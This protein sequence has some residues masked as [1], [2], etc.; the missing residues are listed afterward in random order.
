MRSFV[1][2]NEH[3][4]Y[5]FSLEDLPGF[6]RNFNENKHLFT[7][8]SVPLFLREEL[9]G[10]DNPIFLQNNKNN[11]KI[12]IKLLRDF[13]FPSFIAFA[14]GRK[15]KDK[16]RELNVIFNNEQLGEIISDFIK[17]CIIK[18]K[19]EEEKIDQPL[20]SE[21]ASVSYGSL[22]SS[23]AYSST[24]DFASSISSV[25]SSLAS[26]AISSISSASTSFFGGVTAAAT[27]GIRTLDNDAP[28]SSASP[29]E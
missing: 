13:V 3:F 12:F 19:Q 16:Q 22:T 1:L 9:N 14:C 11:E 21:L 10:I 20:S 28:S 26:G 7:E 18:P 27:E 6:I 25:A 8:D 24:S 2:S 29:R 17:P 23:S 4:D 5:L 15:D